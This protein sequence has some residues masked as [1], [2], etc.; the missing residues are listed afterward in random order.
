MN[1]SHPK[2]GIVVLNWNAYE[3][4]V[5]CMESL[6]NLDYPS[7]EFYI[8]DN[9]STDGSYER[10]FNKF[11][12]CVVILNSSNLGYAGGVNAGI[13]KALEN[14]CSYIWLVNNDAKIINSHAL[15]ALVT[16]CEKDK[17]IGAAGSLIKYPTGEIQFSGGKIQ[18][19]L[20]KGIHFEEQLTEIVET[21]YVTGCSLL[22]PKQVIQKV[23]LISEDYFLY[24]EDADYCKRIREA[25]Y[26]CVVVPESLL[27]HE[28][29]GTS[30]KSPSLNYVYY[31]LRNR[32][33][34][35]YRWLNKFQQ[36][37]FIVLTTIETVLRS[38]RYILLGRKDSLKYLLKAYFDGFKKKPGKFTI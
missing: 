33:L 8:V 27:E 1:T 29:G 18:L 11:K 38:V 20:V 36:L 2:V 32:F 15:S 25:G 28:L 21:E 31:N 7:Y 10:L 22:I 37:I 16:A 26:K 24:Y 30:K 34:F 3:L 19:P 13:N 35:S 9:A 23:G 17:A 12:N 5:E 6:Y 14:K 4:T